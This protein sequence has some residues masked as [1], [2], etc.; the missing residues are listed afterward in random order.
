M[1]RFAVIPTVGLTLLMAALVWLTETALPEV[2]PATA[3][4]FQSIDALDAPL[5]PAAWADA[6]LPLRL[7]QAVT[8]KGEFEVMRH[9]FE[10]AAKP[11]SMWAVYLPYFD[12]AARVYLNG[13]LVGDAG[14][15]TPPV[16]QH[17]KRPALL[18][19]S[20]TLVRTG[21]NELIVYFVE[22]A[23][24]FGKA[25][26]FYVGPKASLEGAFDVRIRA[27]VYAPILTICLTLPILLLVGF[28]MSSGRSEPMLLCF[29]LVLLLFVLRTGNELVVDPWFSHSTHAA[30]FYGTSLCLLAAAY[31][32]VSRLANAHVAAIELGLWLA[33]I[34]ITAWL[35]WLL[36]QDLRIGVLRGNATLRYSSV[37]VLP[38]LLILIVRYLRGEPSWRGGWVSAAL[39]TAAGVVMLDIVRTW[40]PGMPEVTYASFGPPL[41]VGAFALVLAHR[42]VTNATAAAAAN[43]ELAS[44]VAEREAQ[45]VESYQRLREAQ[46]ASLLLEERQRIMRDMHD[47]VG[48]RLAALSSL[49]NRGEAVPTAD[50]RDAV[51]ESLQDLRLM[52]DS[53]DTL[54][55]DLALALGAARPRLAHW[56]RGHGIALEWRC[57]IGQIS[58]FGPRSVLSIYRLLQEACTN[59]ARHAQASRVTITCTNSECALSVCVED[60]GRGFEVLEGGGRGL[61]NMRS[62]VESLGGTF[63]VR[64]DTHGSG[65]YFKIP[66]Q[67]E[68]APV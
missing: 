53:L 61:G 6:T 4:K 27:Q 58:G 23:P 19:I 54:P 10:V 48:G 49:L 50:V 63:E 29:A 55:D 66:S 47:G 65:V 25:G 31:G 12:S 32:F 52:I 43:V 5:D 15:I 22:V 21:R 17:A 8:C 16:G 45:V 36:A 35:N 9:T 67:V 59:V 37:L 62:R 46:E 57:D 68:R 18:D 3:V 30:I 7:C 60:D 28:V 38:I 39:V 33:A 13:A 56:L 41:L 1:W 2:V 20:P 51:G 42:Y 34:A 40:P 11:A 64:S 26:R 24:G 44:R 14:S